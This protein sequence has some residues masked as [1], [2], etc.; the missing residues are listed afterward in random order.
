MDEAR[1]LVIRG[2]FGELI[3]QLEVPELRERIAQAIESELA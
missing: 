3:S 1:K 2:F